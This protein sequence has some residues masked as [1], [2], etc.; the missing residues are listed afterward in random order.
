MMCVDIVSLLGQLKH[1]TF[2]GQSQVRVIGLKLNSDGQFPGSGPFGPQRNQAL[3]S[4]T[5][6]INEFN[7]SSSQIDAF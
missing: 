1:C 2:W 7:S 6:G 5:F 4:L 3:Q